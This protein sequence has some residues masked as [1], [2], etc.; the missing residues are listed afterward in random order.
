MP[1]ELFSSASTRPDAAFCDTS[2]LLDVLTHEVP[3]VAASIPDLDPVKQARAA[4][5]ATFFNDYRSTGTQFVSSPY[6][7]QEIGN[8]VAKYTLKQNAAR[9]R[10]WTDLK[11]ADHAMFLALRAV[12]TRA[13]EDAWRRIQHHG[14]WF[15]VPDNGDDTR[16]G[17]RVNSTVMEAA[18]LFLAAYETL[19]AMDAFHIAMGTACGL[20]WFVTTDAGWKSVTEINIFCDR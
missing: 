11:V 12:A 10:K 15:V 5:A 19:D 1:I 16:F 13:T 18:F 7:L 8:V 2:F 17:N 6:T 3:T 9:Y 14:V 20:D 4:E